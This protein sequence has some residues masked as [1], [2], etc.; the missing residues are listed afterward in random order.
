[1]SVRERP[2]ASFTLSHAW[3]DIVHG[4]AQTRFEALL[5]DVLPAQR[6]FGG[7][8][9]TLRAAHIADAIPLPGG[10][11]DAM[12]LLIDVAYQEGAGETYAL[13]VTSAFGDAAT[14][15]AR[16]ASNAILCRL[17]VDDGGGPRTGVLYDAL[18]EPAIAKT[19]L[20]AIGGGE[21]LSGATGTLR[22]SATAAYRSIIPADGASAVRVLQSEQSN[23]SVA[24]GES[25]ML[26]LY[27]RLQPGVNPDWEIGRLLTSYSFPHS[28]AVGGAMEYVR[29]G[30]TV[31]L[32]LLQAFVPNEGDAWT[33]TLKELGNF[34]S[35]VRAKT[36][37]VDPHAGRDRSLWDLGQMPLPEAGRELMAAGLEIAA[38][39]G[40]RTAALHLTLARPRDDPDFAPEPMTGEYRRAGYESMVR[41]WKHAVA[42]LGRQ[43]AHGSPSRQEA[44]RLLAREPEILAVFRSFMAT[45]DGGLR[46]R[47][48]GD[49]HLGQILYTASDY[50]VTDF[51]GEPARPLGE[52]RTKHSPLYDAA[53]MLRSFDYASWAALADV[54]PAEDRPELEPWRAYWSRWV[55]A[56]FLRAY[57][58]HVEDAPFWPR[59]REAAALLLT[60]HQLEKAVYELAYE[61]NNRPAWA[62]IPMKG[63][64][65]ILR[66]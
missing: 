24:F 15:I 39:L 54:R 43:P 3:Q 18:W 61:L 41:L 27:R 14:R 23:T 57:L 64:H 28:P 8:A 44:E 66:A 46:I 1:M 47:C 38:S 25:A 63:I 4:E 52:R 49:Y 10:T 22:G 30:E 20:R 32:A 11:A 13:A 36:G 34:L 9:R 33:V 59:S 50:I 6:W 12:F 62:A 60:V 21:P 58:I 17:I 19:L 2:P 51:E 53:G 31:T 40:Q 45:N 26:K 35:R 7:K 37:A 56:E 16:E 5:P 29:A 65:E 55:R 42:L 48:H